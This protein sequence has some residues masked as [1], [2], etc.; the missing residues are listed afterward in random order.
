VYL[1]GYG[2]FHIRTKKGTNFN[3]AVVNQQ[4]QPQPPDTLLTAID[5]AMGK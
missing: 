3:F 1:V 4:N 2:A 5:N